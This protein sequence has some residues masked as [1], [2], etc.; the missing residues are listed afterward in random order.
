VHA[1]LNLADS[2][3]DLINL[4][5]ARSLKV[6]M[7]V[8]GLDGTTLSDHTNQVLAMPD[9]RTPVGRLELEKLAAGHAVLVEL[10][11]SDADGGLLDTNIYWWSKDESALRELNSLRPATI[12][13]SVSVANASDERAMTVRLKNNGTV[14]ALLLKLTL[15]D[16][17][18]GA[19]I[20]PAYYSENYISLLPG[21]ES[22]VTLKFP[23]G[24]NQ[25]KLAL[26]GWNLG[27]QVVAMH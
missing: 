9:A 10:A 21:E 22:T 3:V 8:E 26:R 25:T 5:Q 7:L 14:P 2:S 15:E 12:A 23:A 18:T 17:V 13:A 19:R 24:T 16:A 11:A 1:Q 20:L 6:R 27:S 4:G